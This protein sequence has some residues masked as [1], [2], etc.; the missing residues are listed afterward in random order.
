MQSSCP[1][2]LPMR[3][4]P[5]SGYDTCAYAKGDRTMYLRN[6]KL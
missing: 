6:D 5:V 4:S 2:L 1:L 3:T